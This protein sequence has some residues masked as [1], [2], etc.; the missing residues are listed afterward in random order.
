MKNSI[1][2]V[3]AILS[4]QV[5]SAFSDDSLSGTYINEK[6]EKSGGAGK[7]LLHPVSSDVYLFS[8]N[9]NLGAPSYN[10]GQLFGELTVN[11]STSVYENNEYKFRGKGCKWKITFEQGVAKIQTVNFSNKCGLGNSVY[12]DGSY[13]LKS[14]EVPD[15]YVDTLGNTVKFSVK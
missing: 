6:L 8:L 10:S 13:T 14:A 12:V 1:L 4:L 9:L 5:S 3:I 11:G 2:I 7:L 15:T